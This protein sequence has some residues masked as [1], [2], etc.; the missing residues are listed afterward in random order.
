MTDSVLYELNGH[1]PALDPTA[2]AAPGAKIIGQVTLEAGSS[3]WFNAV[4]RGDSAPITVGKNTNIQDNT[5]V[6]VE[7]ATERLDGK[8][9]PVIIGANV[10]VGHNCIIHGCVIED[11]CIIGMQAVVMNGARVGT[12][13]IVGAGAVVL[14]NVQIPPYSLVVGSPAVVKKTYPPEVVE[15]IR[16]SAESYCQRVAAFKTLKGI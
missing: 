15:L 4:L 16:K 5:T 14:E 13:S 7:S 12:G 6:H 11:D 3:V 1:R 2:W 8:P 10:T 9:C